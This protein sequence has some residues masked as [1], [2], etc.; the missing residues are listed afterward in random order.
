ML[1]TLRHTHYRLYICSAICFKTVSW[2]SSIKPTDLRSRAAFCRSLAARFLFPLSPVLPLNLPSSFSSLLPDID[3]NGKLDLQ[4][5]IDIVS[6]FDDSFTRAQIAKMWLE[7]VGLSGRCSCAHVFARARLSLSL[8]V[9]WHAC[10]WAR[11]PTNV[12]KHTLNSEKT[13][14][15]S[16]ATLFSPSETSFSCFLSKK[17]RLHHATCPYWQRR[18]GADSPI[19]VCAC[20]WCGVGAWVKGRGA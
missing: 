2:R 14:S 16:R 18:A 8:F 6:V 13:A 3:G 10:A 7:I 17:T 5:F 9:C 12:G 4:E 20:A 11:V 1:A 19:G 15:A